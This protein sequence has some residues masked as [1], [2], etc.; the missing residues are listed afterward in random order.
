MDDH[1][2]C[3]K[4][5]RINLSA[6]S[7]YIASRM[8]EV[9]SYGTSA[10]PWVISAPTGQRLNLTLFNF[11]RFARSDASPG[12]LPADPSVCYEIATILDGRNRKNIL[13]CG[14][15]ERVKSVYV[16]RGSK[17]EIRFVDRSVLRNLGQFLIHFKGKGLFICLYYRDVPTVRSFLAMAFDGT[18][19]SHRKQ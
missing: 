11:A 9:Y 6:P 13:T 1:H 19:N 10:C 4:S 7:G 12:L 16:S 5:G 18:V 3:T 17:V 15:D 8:A 2:S 14:T